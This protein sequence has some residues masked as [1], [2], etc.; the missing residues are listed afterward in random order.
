MAQALREFLD[1]L[2]LQ[3]N[4]I[5]VPSRD[6]VVVEIECDRWTFWPGLDPKFIIDAMER[7]V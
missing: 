3:A 6:M 1:A 4:V 2:G 7:Y 5:D